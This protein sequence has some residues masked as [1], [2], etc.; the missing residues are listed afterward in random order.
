MHLLVNLQIICL[1]SFYL[2]KQFSCHK[3]FVI[4]FQPQSKGA[5]SPTTEEWIEFTNEIPHSKEFTSCLWLKTN[6]YNQMIPFMLWSYCTAESADD[7]MRCLQVYLKA[8]P[9]SLQRNVKIEAW[10]PSNG[11]RI[12]LVREVKGFLHRKWI[13]FCWSVSSITRK[14][15]FYYNGQLLVKNPGLTAKNENVLDDSTEMIDT[16]LIFG[17]EPDKL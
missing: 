4:H 10:I 14:N 5:I 9:E 6:Y 16:A 2:T 15:Q 11:Q 3:S 17:Q 7:E 13:H 8:F 1:I 12:K